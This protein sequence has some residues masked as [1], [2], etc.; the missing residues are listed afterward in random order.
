MSTTDTEI[1][2]TEGHPIHTY[3][4]ETELIHELLAEI[5]G[6]R[7]EKGK[8]RMTENEYNKALEF[9]DDYL[10]TLVLNM[11]ESPT[12]KTIEN[13]VKNLVFKKEERV[14]KP[15]TEYHLMNYIF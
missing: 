4:L 3:L 1:Q 13:P 7:A 12:F 6:I 8:F 14:S 11:N 9:K 10:I 2:L 5:K 15:I